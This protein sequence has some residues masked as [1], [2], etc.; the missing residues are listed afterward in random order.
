MPW[1]KKTDHGQVA[2]EIRIHFGGYFLDEMKSIAF[3]FTV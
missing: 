2:G 1:N 3:E